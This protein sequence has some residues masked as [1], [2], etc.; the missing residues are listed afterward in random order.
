MKTYKET[1][2]GIEKFYVDVIRYNIENPPTSIRREWYVCGFRIAFEWRSSE[3]LMGR[4]GG[5][6]NWELGFQIGGNTVIFNLL[7]ATLR[8]DNR[9]KG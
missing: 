5:G 8:I 2:T 4:F 6:W 9:R 7:V 1:L 3:N